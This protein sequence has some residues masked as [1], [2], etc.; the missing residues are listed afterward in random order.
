MSYVLNHEFVQIYW[1]IVTWVRLMTI[2]CLDRCQVLQY[3]CQPG[4]LCLVQV[5][6]HLSVL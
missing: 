1:R 2:L 6:L 3:G 5:G 4:V